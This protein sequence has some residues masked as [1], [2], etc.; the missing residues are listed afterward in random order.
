MNGFF[1]HVQSKSIINELI[2]RGDRIKLHHADHNDSISLTGRA[3]FW[4]R[5]ADCLFMS[6][7]RVRQ[8]Q[9]CL[10]AACVALHETCWHHCGPRAVINCIW[11]SSHRPK[12]SHFIYILISDLF[13]M[14]VCVPQKAS[15]ADYHTYFSKTCESILK[16]LIWLKIWGE[17]ITGRR[18]KIMKVVGEKDVIYL[19]W[20]WLVEEARMF[21]QAR[22]SEGPWTVIY[23]SVVDVL[24][25]WA[26][27]AYPSQVWSPIPGMDMLHGSTTHHHSDWQRFGCL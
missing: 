23:G 26:Y 3:D 8:L 14:M 5:L 11:I 27:R 18:G 21:Q 24:M 6:A 15:H 17:G 7:K 1:I 12:Q 10:R 13:Y 20:L 22:L 2:Y 4:G 9:L 25:D 19:Q 16:K